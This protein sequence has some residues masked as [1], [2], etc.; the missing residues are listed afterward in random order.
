MVCLADN[1]NWI[2]SVLLQF[3]FQQINIELNCSLNPNFKFFRANECN[4]SYSIVSC[5]GHFWVII[6]GFALFFQ[7]FVWLSKISIMNV[8]WDNIS[9]TLAI[10][11][12]SFAY[13]YCK[14]FH[15]LVCD[16]C[17]ILIFAHHLLFM[18]AVSTACFLFSCFLFS[19]NFFPS[20]LIYHKMHLKVLQ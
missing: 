1:C 10:F 17:D 8:I 20:W 2:Q 15:F 19:R 11:W 13:T 4:F 5:C 14:S 16:N 12:N 9:G 3:T 6:T 7:I 18:L